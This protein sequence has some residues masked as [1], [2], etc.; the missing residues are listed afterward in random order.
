MVMLN[1]ERLSKNL[2]SILLL[3]IS[4]KDTKISVLSSNKI[5]LE[6]SHWALLDLKMNC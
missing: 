3:F 4:L 5:L 6:T 2:F 1:G